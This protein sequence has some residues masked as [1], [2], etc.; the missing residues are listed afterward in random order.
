M[1]VPGGGR[2]A[3]SLAGAILVASTHV[4]RVPASSTRAELPEP[5]PAHSLEVPR[6]MY[7]VDIAL[8]L[9]PID[10]RRDLLYSSLPETS[11]VPSARSGAITSLAWS[12]EARGTT[13]LENPP[14]YG[15]MFLKGWIPLTAAEFALLG[16]TAALPRSWTGWSAHFV[17]DGVN[18]LERA[19]TEPPVW[20][21][22]WWVHNY[23]GHPYG[24]ALY[25]NTV[26]AQGATPIQSMFFSAALSTQWEYFFEAFAERP[27]IQDLLITPIV[28][29][30][31]G[32]A[33]HRLT[34]QL[35]K[36]GTTPLEKIVILI[37][38]P[39]HVAF[40]GF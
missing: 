24:G 6:G 10:F 20:D 32:E 39:M 2:V 3:A 31:L 36:G 35:Q 21:D 18:H 17:R 33:S 30:A 22:D 38:N 16:V 9:E 1:R 29:S 11:P 40:A 34:L 25:Y 5:F 13:P 27:S 15:R 23:V 28:G 26:R 37:T 19:Y 4:P 14:S 7:P 8:S 12:E